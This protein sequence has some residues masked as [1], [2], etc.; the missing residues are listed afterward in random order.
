MRKR[1]FILIEVLVSTGLFLLLVT[2]MF[3]IFWRSSKT[4][5][6]INKL[7]I[8]NEQMLIAQSKLQNIFSAATFVKSVQP[9]FFI[10]IERKSGQPSLICTLDSPVQTHSDFSGITISRIYL[11]DDK[12]VVATFPHLEEGIPEIIQKETLLSG[13][14]KLDIELFFAPQ[15]QEKIVETENEE[16]VKKPPEGVWTDVW[17]K[18][19]N[20]APT[21]AKL[22]IERGK[23]GNFTLYFFMPYMIDTI[24]YGKL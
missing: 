5:N 11:E 8:V 2:A 7:R 20:Q 18:E 22:K 1:S 9:Y 23:A 16:T 4:N 17:P 13:V 3:G 19:Y 21:L 12:L 15:S 10:E 24:L 6:A 14:T